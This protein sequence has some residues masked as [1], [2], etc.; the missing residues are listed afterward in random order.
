MRKVKIDIT[1]NGAP[2]STVAIK[3]KDFKM[4]EKYAAE[5]GMTVDEYIHD[6]IKNASG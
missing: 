1:V 3:K 6:V 2:L 4:I 5:H